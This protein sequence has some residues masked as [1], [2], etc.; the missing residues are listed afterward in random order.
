[1]TAAVI[2]VFLV[3]VLGIPT[4]LGMREANAR[5]NADIAHL[6]KLPEPGEAPGAVE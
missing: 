3:L 6:R 2:V 5:I 1:M 4:W